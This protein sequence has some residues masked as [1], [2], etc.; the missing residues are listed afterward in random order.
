MVRLAARRGRA[1]PCGPRGRLVCA[2]SSRRCWLS[3]SRREFAAWR[4]QV[5]FLASSNPL[6]TRHQRFACRDGDERLGRGLGS[7]GHVSWAEQLCAGGEGRAPSWISEDGLGALASKRSRQCSARTLPTAACYS[8]SP[9]RI[10]SE[11]GAAGR[12][13]DKIN[14][15]DCHLE[16]ASKLGSQ[17]SGCQ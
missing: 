14:C 13:S 7:P 8:I 2:R 3:A 9:R 10:K 4:E 11:S 17:V 5:S 1:A 16:V 6:S 15:R 12:K